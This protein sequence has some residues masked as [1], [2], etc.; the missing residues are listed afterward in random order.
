MGMSGVIPNKSPMVSPRNHHHHHRLPLV[1]KYE[2]P[3]VDDDTDDDQGLLDLTVKA[4]P[5]PKHQQVASAIRE[6]SHHIIKSPAARKLLL[7]PGNLLR[8]PVTTLLGAEDLSPSAGMSR[9][10]AS[11]YQTPD[12]QPIRKSISTG[13]LNKSQVIIST[14]ICISLDF[15]VKYI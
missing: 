9:K 2:A 12:Q 14:L 15:P 1:P 5:V 11:P 7:S 4:S 3:P 6:G 13:R 8:S 10:R